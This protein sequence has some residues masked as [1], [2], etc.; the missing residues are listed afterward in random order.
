MV[1]CR[2]ISVKFF[3]KYLD[4]SSD[5]ASKTEFKDGNKTPILSRDV[6]IWSQIGVIL[7]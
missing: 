3:Q 6:V 4:M 7:P 1:D 2:E 5:C